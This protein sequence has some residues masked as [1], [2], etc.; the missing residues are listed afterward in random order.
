MCTSDAAPVSE[1]L[2]DIERQLLCHAVAATLL[3][4]RAGTA[5]LDDP[6]NGMNWGAE[7]QVRADLLV[8]LL[9]ATLRPDGRIPRS[10]KLRG[11]RIIGSLNLEAATL[12]CPLLLQDCHVDEPVNLGEATAPAIR[13][14]GS[15]LPALTARQLRTSG[16]VDLN[17]AVFTTRGEV[18]LDGARIG[19]YLDLDGATLT[20]PG[21]TALNAVQITVDLSMYCGEG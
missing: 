5:E 16:D 7:R 10:I 15:Y 11:A 17:A 13:M 8:A 4:L 9:T 21:G 3:D 1:T 14:L 19:G 6:A 12:I 18:R 20:N 2:S